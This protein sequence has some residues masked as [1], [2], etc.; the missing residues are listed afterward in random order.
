VDQGPVAGGD[1]APVPAGAP[2]DELMGIT[3]PAPSVSRVGVTDVSVEPSPEEEPPAGPTAA[4]DLGGLTTDP[5]LT[6]SMHPKIRD[7]LATA[8]P[9]TSS[10]TVESLEI[11]G[12]AVPLGSYT[13]LYPTAA[14]LAPAVDEDVAPP[15][16]PGA[17]SVT[18]DPS[19]GGD[20]PGG[21][22]GG[23]SPAA[24]AIATRASEIGSLGPLPNRPDA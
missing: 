6:F 19:G 23:A 7:L 11:V 20:A 15:T 24:V 4:G 5:D 13:M 17:G 1:A 9:L 18:P 10:T 3:D 12:T 21:L 16:D 2:A 8:H 14:H 22:G